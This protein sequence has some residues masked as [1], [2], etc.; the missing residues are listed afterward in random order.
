[1]RWGHGIISV[2]D[3]SVSDVELQAVEP[4]GV[5]FDADAHKQVQ[6]GG[7]GGDGQPVSILHE[8]QTGSSG[9]EV[10]SLSE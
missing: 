8:G 5:G 4:D 2:Y 3:E 6:F 10:G 1:V 7:G 9:F